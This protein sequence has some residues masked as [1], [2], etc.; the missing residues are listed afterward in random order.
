ML[1]PSRHILIY[2]SIGLFI[3]I[4]YDILINISDV[5]HVFS[6]EL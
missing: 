5:F 2:V 4:L 6:D 1:D 3:Y